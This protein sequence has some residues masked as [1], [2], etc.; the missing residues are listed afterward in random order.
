MTFAHFS[1]ASRALAVEEKRIESESWKRRALE[2][3]VALTELYHKTICGT[4]DERHAALN[5]AWAIIGEL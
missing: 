4:D 5:A 1:L 3:E 2:A